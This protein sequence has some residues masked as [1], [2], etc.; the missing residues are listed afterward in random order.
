LAE[1]REELSQCFLT[2][3]ASLAPRA[4]DPLIAR[5][6]D[7]G[8]E[9]QAGLL[10]ATARKPDPADR[11]DDF[12]K[13]YQVLE[14]AIVRLLGAAH[15]DRATIE[16]VPTYESVF[17]PRPEETLSPA[18]VARQRAE[19]SLGRY[20]AAVHY[21]RYYDAL[22]PEELVA[23]IFPV[24]ADGSV[25]PFVARVFARSSTLAVEAAR[26]A[27]GM[28]AGRVARMTAM[29]VLHAAGSKEAEAV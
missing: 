16:R 18:N 6:R 14:I 27:L 13:L 9:K 1:V 29:R 3:L 28:Q 7:L 8:L 10:D 21:A 11:L 12:V 17:V 15:V 22:S 23:N 5:L 25:A 19:G 4:T 26:K 20:E 2:G 24:W